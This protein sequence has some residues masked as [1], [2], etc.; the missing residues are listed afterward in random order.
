[1]QRILRASFPSPRVTLSFPTV[2]SVPGTYVSPRFTKINPLIGGRCVLD[3]GICI[4][5]GS[6][7]H[8]ACSNLFLPYNS[9]VIFLCFLIAKPAFLSR[10]A[11]HEISFCS[12]SHIKAPS[13]YADRSPREGR[14][15]TNP[16]RLFLL[17]LAPQ[18]CQLP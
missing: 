18:S 8:A 10:L 1:M 12:P 11:M 2:C 15:L 3:K 4:G 14:K 5:A 17:K 13:C 7:V 16:P 9:P 6:G